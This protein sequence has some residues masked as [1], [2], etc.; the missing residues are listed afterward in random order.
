[1]SLPVRL[2]ALIAGFSRHE[3]DAVLITNETDI[4]YLTQYPA[5]DAW[6]LVTPRQAFYITD[7]RY[8]DEVKK[9][10]A[11]V[12]PVKF[13]KSIFV[14]TVAL[15][16]KAGIKCL[17]VEERH[18]TVYEHKRL[19]SFYNKEISMV[20]VDDLVSSL[21][22]IK[23]KKEIS[24]MREAIGINLSAYQAIEPLIKPGV[25]EQDV[26]GHLEIFI[27]ERGV[28]FSF[29]P[30]IASGPNSAYPHARVTSRKFRSNEP[31]LV[32]LG[33]D[34]KGYKSDLTRMF[35]LGRMPT[36]FADVLSVLQDAQHEA[37]KMICPGVLSKDVDEVVRKYLGKHE[38]AS[39]F[40]HS[41][42]HGVGLDIH[43]EPKLSRASEVVLQ[44]N[45]VFTVEPGVYFPG[46][47]G[48]RLEEMVL[49]TKKG[50]EVLSR[51]MK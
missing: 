6:L 26:L 37:F 9:E 3:V 28:K 18:L 21:R 45:M 47:Y 40:T 49:V 17:G 19:K 8:I 7:S 14:E 15:A 25:S 41:L 24:L 29:D 20:P 22:M 46:K 31:V 4:R 39:R 13:E 33:I 5:H 50:C 43:E 27:R 2:Q 36:S 1:M 11:G 12:V 10:I 32:D 34:V 44:E 51:N 30:I 48:M 16:Y 23:D 35:F 38:L 42:G